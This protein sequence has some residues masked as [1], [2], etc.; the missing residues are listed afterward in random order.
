MNSQELDELKSDARVLRCYGSRIKLQK[1]GNKYK[2][3]C[4]FHGE[5]TPSFVV[6]QDLR[7]HCYG[8]SESG[9]VMQFVAK[10]DS[11]S[12][13]EAAEKVKQEIGSSSWEQTKQKVEHTFKS[14]ADT[15]TYK[16]APLSSFKHLEEALVK[17]EEAI[18]WLK[19]KRGIAFETAQRLHLGFVQN[20]G[21]LAG[22]DGAEVADKGWIAL[23]CVSGEE[24]TSVKY[25]SIYAK[26]FSRQPGM[27][28]S[29]WNTETIDVFKPIYVVEGEFDACVLEQAGFHAVSVPSAGTKLTPE[30][31]DLIMSASCVVLA[32]DT[33]PVG[34]GYMQKL[35]VE[36]KE[37]CYFLK[38]PETGMKDANQTFLEA[39]GRDTTKFKNLVDELTSKAKSQPMPDIYAIQD[40]M[41]NG[42]DTSLA[43]R[44]DRL[45]FPWK[46]V[47]DAAILLPG[48]VLGVMATATGQGKT[49][50]TLQYSLFGARKYN[51]TVVNWQCELSP[52]EI[53]VMVAAQVL[54]KNRNFIT[55]EDLK[56]AAEELDGVQYYIGNNSTI[57]NINEVLDIMEAAIRRTGATQAV[58]DNIHYYTS[59]VD[60]DVRVLAAALKRI[61]Q[62]SITYGVK[63]TVVFQPRKA[64]Q[65]T[66]GKKV[67]ISDVKGSASAGDTCDA[68]VA[69]HRELAK[70][71]EGDEA[72][73][74][75][76]DEKTLVEWLKTRSKGIGK[77]SSTVQFFGEFASFE[78]LD[79]N[80]EEGTNDTSANY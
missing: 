69:I 15:K 48:S 10:T 54:R 27:A 78:S 24:I 26:K 72:K 46:A 29:L 39:C 52:S 7:F 64:S 9:N 21:N 73:N 53:S 33:D 17:S 16:T 20:I 42:E 67:Q 18:G 37:K 1:E 14:M 6:H 36:L 12:F 4:P 28:T 79:L 60:D 51:E 32:G 77:A 50:F 11:I 75:I 62:M 31:K 74:D 68:V 19:D 13:T 34:S 65:Q 59:G 8:C 63:F 47:D 66:R 40:V 49:A 61:K 76:Y 45:R 23:P 3:L 44:P 25:R 5:K 22:A 35:W 2:G 57:N 58:L 38:W 80:H 55:K 56:L 71:S 30:M 70:S 43:D 41:K